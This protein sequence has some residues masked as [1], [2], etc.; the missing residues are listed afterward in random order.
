[1]SLAAST[2]GPLEAALDTWARGRLADIHRDRDMAARFVHPGSWPEE[3][4]AEERA[5]RRALTNPVPA[6]SS[7]NTTLEGR[8][9]R[10]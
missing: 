7:A 2:T 5:V 1:M 8:Y 3:L 9:D 6:V 4:A 10:P